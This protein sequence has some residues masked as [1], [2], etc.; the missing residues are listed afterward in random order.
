MRYVNC[1][2]RGNIMPIRKLVLVL[3]EVRFGWH[4]WHV[5][6]FAGMHDNFAQNE[7]SL[8]KHARKFHAID[9][10]SICSGNFL[11]AALLRLKYAA[12]APIWLYIHPV[13]TLSR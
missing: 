2:D 6:L 5:V 3:S 13:E 8:R 9:L 10:M 4:G 12:A 1:Q 7:S 11:K